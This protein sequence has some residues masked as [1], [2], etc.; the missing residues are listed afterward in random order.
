[1]DF[2][3][4]SCLA[5]QK[6]QNTSAETLAIKTTVEIPQKIKFFLAKDETSP[7][8]ES[9]NARKTHIETLI[10]THIEIHIETFKFIT[11]SIITRLP[12]KHYKVDLLDI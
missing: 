3:K 5:R 12:K 4:K 1:M 8:L 7:Q 9:K 6:I 10:E 11:L 2:R